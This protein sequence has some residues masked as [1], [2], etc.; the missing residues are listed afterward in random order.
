MRRS[1]LSTAVSLALSGTY[2]SSYPSYGGW[3]AP[4][5]P[6]SPIVSK[7]RQCA[8]CHVGIVSGRHCFNCKQRKRT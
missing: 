2:S 5:A 4:T 6:V 8:S 1:L 7:E 3:D